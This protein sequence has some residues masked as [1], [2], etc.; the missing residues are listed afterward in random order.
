MGT[1]LTILV[2]RIFNFQFADDR[3]DDPESIALIE[4]LI[5]ALKMI[6]KT[7]PEAT[8]TIT[9]GSTL[10]HQALQYE[11]LVRSTPLP[12]FSTALRLLLDNYPLATKVR[13]RSGRLPLHMACLYARNDKFD[14]PIL[15][16]YRLLLMSY[17]DAIF[18]Q[19]K[20]GKTPLHYH[21]EFQLQLESEHFTDNKL[22]TK[23]CCHSH[24]NMVS[25]RIAT[26]V[27]WKAAC[28]NPLVF[29]TQDS[30]GVTPLSSL[31]NLIYIAQIDGEGLDI[32]SALR[33]TSY[34][35]L[36]REHPESSSLLIR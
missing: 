30:D 7:K 36:L 20:Y 34:Y 22:C 13:D 11:G 3:H 19:D 21:L 28:L 4:N 16:L 5:E 35:T 1:P 14:G 9:S 32:F 25:S 29:L 24:I 17:P 27:L 12:L 6:L 33:A 18:S 8:M 2:K 10:V 26:V 15:G 23:E 31:D